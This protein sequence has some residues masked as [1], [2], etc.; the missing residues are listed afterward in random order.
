[1]QK[2]LLV[3]A[4]ATGVIIVAV[5]VGAAALTG[6]AP[7]AADPSAAI[8][9]PTPTWSHTLNDRKKQ[10]YFGSPGV[11]TLDGGGPAV[12]VGNQQGR[13]YAW[14]V[15]NGSAVA[16]WPWVSSSSTSIQSTPAVAGSGRNTKVLVGLG[17]S[18]SPKKGG[19]LALTASG[20][21][22]WFYSPYLLPHSRGGHRGVMSSLAVG[23]IQTGSDVVGGSMGQMQDAMTVSKGK[24]LKGFGWL[25][26]D[27]NFSSPAL[28]DLSHTGHDDI[29]EGGD[30]SKG[31]AG[32]THYTNGGHIRILGHR[33]NYGKKYLNSGLVCQYNTT[34]VVQSAP[35]VGGFLAGG[36]NGIVVG[37]G[38][39]FKTA[40]D[41]HKLIAINTK[42]K[43]QWSI[44]LEGSSKPSP[45]IA[46]VNGDGKLDVVANSEHGDVYALNG[47]NGHVIW[48]TETGL[49][50]IG[51]VVTFAA[52]G[53]TFQYLVV[54][55]ANGI[56]IL[57][58]R[59]G[60]IVQSRIGADIRLLNTPLVTADPSGQIGITI[61]GTGPGGKS[62]I[63]H[64]VVNGTS[65]VTSVQTYGAW[66]MYHLNPQLTG[67][68]P[69]KP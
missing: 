31:I 57:D 23:P 12:L 34:Q 6:T 17:V 58:G 45:A 62:K 54:P 53:N 7:A 21:K 36:A 10:F 59:T 50:T 49:A 35:A 64:F 22:S 55:T 38:T 32:A 3:R 33:G 39:F 61:A 25:Q 8:V 67:Y 65:G 15:S 68:A 9:N 20:K 47:A 14:H 11:G 52:P 51:S 40:S 30:S 5:A 66:P 46:D 28:A 29:I 60:A 43:K 41:R 48:K 2:R 13:L 69:A 56:D 63:D 24:K 37:T 27:T 1:M 4:R 16:G 44:T 42:C 26:A 18:T 19:Y